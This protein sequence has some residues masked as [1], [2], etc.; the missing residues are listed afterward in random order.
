MKKDVLRENTAVQERETTRENAAEQKSE[1]ARENAAEQEDKAA[2]ENAAVQESGT[3]SE[4]TEVQENGTLSENTAEQESGTFRYDAF[5]SY[6]HAPLDQ[7]VAQTLQR[8]LES[9]K[10]PRLADRETKELGKKSIR[11]IFRDRD[12]LPLA[13]NLSEPIME[14]LSSSEHLIVICSPRILESEWCKREIETFISLRGIEHV[15]AVLVEGEPVEAFPEPL[16]AIKKEVVSEDGSVTV[17]EIPVEPLAADVRGATKAEV[18]KKIRQEMLRLAAP[19]IGCSYDDL[20]QRHKM[21]RLKRMLVSAAVI[22]GVLFLFGAFSAYQAFRIKRQSDHIAAQ[23]EEIMAQSEEILA[24]SKE[25]IAQSEEIQEQAQ[26][27]Y[28]FQSRSLSE[29]ALQ[30]YQSGDRRRALLVALEGIPDDL[31]H[32]DR[33]VVA[34]SEAALAEIL[35]V[36]ANGSEHRPY[37]LFEHDARTESMTVSPAGAYLATVDSMG[38]LYCWDIREGALLAKGQEA[39]NTDYEIAP[40]FI[41]E[42]RILYVGQDRVV[43]VDSK[44]LDIQYT[45]P[46]LYV[47]AIAVS[48]DRS[49]LAVAQNRYEVG[50]YDTA[51]GKLVACYEDMQQT[52]TIGWELTFSEDGSR[53]LF[54]GAYGESEQESSVREAE[55]TARIVSIDARTCEVLAEYQIPHKYISAIY[56]TSEGVCYVI[57][58]G[59]LITASSG[60]EVGQSLTC[61]EPDGRIRWEVDDEESKSGPIRLFEGTVIY[62]S[63]KDVCMVSEADGSPVQELHYPADVLRLSVNEESRLIA[64]TLDDGTMRFDVMT[65]MGVVSRTYMEPSGEWMEDVLSSRD[66]MILQQR[67]SNRIYLYRLAC[68]AN[69]RE[70]ADTEQVYYRSAAD[71]GGKL[72][73]YDYDGYFIYDMIAQETLA[74]YNAEDQGEYIRGFLAIED[75]FV[76]ITKTEVRVI[77]AETGWLIGSEEKELFSWALAG[78]ELYYVTY[79]GKFGKMELPSC[80]SSEISSE[81]SPEQLL[82]SGDGRFAIGYDNYGGDSCIDLTSGA[83]RELSTSCKLMAADAAGETYLAADNETM[84]LARFRFGESEPLM[85]MD[86]QLAFIKN[87]GF[88]PDG[89]S[90]FV[91]YVDNRLEIYDAESFTLLQSYQDLDGI[92]EWKELEEGR[93]LLCGETDSSADSYILD[94]DHNVLYRI[95]RCRAVSTELGRAYSVLGTTLYEYPLYDLERLVEEAREV[96]GEDAALTPEERKIYFIE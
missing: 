85:R 76:V 56:C 39:V 72:Y 89:S 96:L 11:R 14:A 20:R 36:Y 32:P 31:D 35:Q 65:D 94:A 48:P 87:I 45:I 82:I 47:T 53:V 38:Q 51:D 61:F 43:C 5:I 74:Q 57:G 80:Q 10:V 22:A 69:M 34:Q 37:A 84:Q 42:E 67:A 50:I 81:F 62:R 88:S 28:A 59:S 27:L 77:D 12:E 91:C 58:I 73:L 30:L 54:E 1:A 49:L 83:V 63:G 52:E 9:F 26:S 70:A 15:F 8:R 79:G 66:V 93:T 68:G 44:N 18:G 86:A 40:V 33:P 92:A 24:Q 2:R 17:Q 64:A 23:S 78:E 60:V 75:A 21:R 29:T 95:P 13:G 55:D 16:R 41:S 3:P 7:Y 19:M 90:F 6:R 46:E 71:E 4:S 25:I